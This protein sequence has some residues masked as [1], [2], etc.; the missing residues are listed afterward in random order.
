MF[1]AMPYGALLKRA[2]P[3]P[4]HAVRC[5]AI[6]MT[7]QGVSCRSVVKLLSLSAHTSVYM[8]SMFCLRSSSLVLRKGKDLLQACKQCQTACGHMAAHLL[9]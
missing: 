9:G 6:A 4:C 1:R 2:T 5:R 8:Y 7:R 3:G